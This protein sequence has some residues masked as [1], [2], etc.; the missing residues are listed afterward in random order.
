MKTDGKKE[1]NV[2][3]EFFSEQGLRNC[4]I[5]TLLRN[6]LDPH[7]KYITEDIQA[8]IDSNIDQIRE[9]AWIVHDS[10]RVLEA[11][12]AYYDQKA[13]D[14]GKDSP[15]YGYY[16]SKSIGD[17][18]PPHVHIVIRFKAPKQRKHIAD[19]FGVRV[20]VVHSYIGGKKGARFGLAVILYLL[21]INRPDKHR[22]DASEIHCNPAMQEELPRLIRE[23]DVS[24]RVKKSKTVD[25]ILEEMKEGKTLSD[26]R[27]D[28]D[29]PYQVYLKN[30]KLFAEAEADFR[31]Y[32]LT[33]PKY[34]LNIYVKGDSGTGKTSIA[35]ML[36]R[37]LYPGIE[38]P[39]YTTG[40][41]G[42]V[43]QN[44]AGEK[45]ILWDDVTADKINDMA[46]AGDIQE[47]L[48]P[49]QQEKAPR[50]TKYSYVIPSN[51]MNIFTST[52]DHE[53]FF[54][55]LKIGDTSEEQIYRRIPVLIKIK[56]KTIKEEVI[57]G[58][59]EEAEREEI[60]I[61]VNRG[62]WYGNPSEWKV[63]EDILVA[64]LDLKKMFKTVPNDRFA[65]IMNPVLEMMKKIINAV[66]EKLSKNSLSEKREE[67]QKVFEVANSVKLNKPDWKF[68]EGSDFDKIERGR[69]KK[70]HEL[71]ESA[72]EEHLIN[73]YE[74]P[75]QDAG[76]Y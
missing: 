65:D 27:N 24:S 74:G 67:E 73:S 61:C 51:E 13:M 47:W 9:Y 33:L 76:E 40:S 62:E 53:V 48:D 10:D 43:L 14:V 75:I 52:Q 30:K 22:Y 11:D 28:P 15:W 39:Y 20:D 4:T 26:V 18:K 59:E 21:H 58:F 54:S 25:M 56:K 32:D 41:K 69:R 70:L 12:M 42:V 60:Y 1:K 6:P 5:V 64:E 16:A 8:V 68:L 35:K 19:L 55:G 37:Y 36:A 23:Y 50:N 44:Y 66:V 71:L 34:L 2:N 49:H 45:V 3:A 17:L 72:A 46:R 63:Y 29:V 38:N 7:E 31:L 57:K